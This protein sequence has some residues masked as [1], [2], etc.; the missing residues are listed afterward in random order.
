[1]R[2]GAIEGHSTH[3]RRK[4]FTNASRHFQVSAVSLKAVEGFGCLSRVVHC[5]PRQ[6]TVLMGRGW[7]LEDHRRFRLAS[8]RPVRI[9]LG[10]SP[11]SGAFL[12][13]LACGP[14]ANKVC[15]SRSPVR[16]TEKVEGG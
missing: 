11:D 10:K 5:R 14:P 13:K 4:A 2:L 15:C 16:A 9:F 3:R 7:V 1:M 12:K 6:P 8:G